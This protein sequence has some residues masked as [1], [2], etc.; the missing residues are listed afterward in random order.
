MMLELPNNASGIGREGKHEVLRNS[1]RCLI[2]L[3]CISRSTIWNPKC[4]R[5][6]TYPN[7]G[8]KQDAKNNRTSDPIRGKHFSRNLVYLNL[9]DTTL[10][11]ITKTKDKFQLSP[12][13]IRVSLPFIL[14][15]SKI[16]SWTDIKAGL[17]C[18]ESIEIAF[19][20][21][22]NQWRDEILEFLLQQ[23]MSGLIS[24]LITVFWLDRKSL[25]KRKIRVSGSLKSYAQVDRLNW[26]SNTCQVIE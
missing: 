6:I 19:I 26:E 11:L 8:R 5:C 10:H 3:H 17:C 24:L 9:V 13:Q 23:Q 21:S 1:N 16:M 22:H 7:Q 12:F 18:P 20:T 2:Q 4:C 25:V 15:N 14:L